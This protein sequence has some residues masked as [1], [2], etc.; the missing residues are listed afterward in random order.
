MK[1]LA[2]DGH[3][4]DSLAEK[5]IDDWLYIRKIPH[6]IHV[7][8]PKSKMTADFKVNGL[9]I[10][11]FGL[12]GESEKYDNLISK[13]EILWEENNLEVIKIYPG[14]LFPKN[15]LGEILKFYEG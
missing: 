7:P 9:L 12:Q 4:C 14:D 1:Y 3:K 10:E 15:R 11:F 13:K 8:Y 2:N 5:I 6:Q